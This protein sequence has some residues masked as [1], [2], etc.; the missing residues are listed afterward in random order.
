MGHSHRLLGLLAHYSQ[1]LVSQ[2]W[3]PELGKSPREGIGYPPQYSGASL[4]AQKVNNPATMR[5]TW[6]RSPGWEDP[7]KGDMATCSGILAWRIPMDGG[8][9]W[10]TVHGVA[11]SRTQPS[12]SV[13]HTIWPNG[14]VHAILGRR[15][16]S[17]PPEALFKN[18][19]VNIMYYIIWFTE[20]I[21]MNR[22]SG[23]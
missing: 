2:C 18:A 16:G 5:E 21:I 19:A 13:Q 12:D 8:A 22:I 6:V 14:W 17:V 23:T 10:V 9:W 4:A 11:E 3:T 15:G 20:N 1:H 7:A